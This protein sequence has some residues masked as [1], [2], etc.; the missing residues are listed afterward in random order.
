MSSVPPLLG[1]AQLTALDWGVMLAYFVATTWIGARLAGEQAT[2]RDFF[3][4]GRKLPWPAVAG[5]IV[6]TEISAVTFVS[7][8]FV[9]FRDGGDF[10]Y[11]Q[12]GVIGSLLARLVVGYVLVPAYYRREIFSPYDY[13]GNR[14]GPGVRRVTT[15]LF[16]LGGIL[17]QSARVYLTAIVLEL[18]LAESVYGPLEAATGIS[19]LAWAIGTIG[20]VAIA[21]TLLGG[22]STVIWTDVA[23]FL[24]FLGGAVAAIVVIALRLDGGFAE[25]VDVGRAA[26]KFRFLDAAPDPT[27]T[28]TIWTA[29]IASTWFMTGIFGTDQLMAQRMFCC[30]SE[31][32]ARK[33]I[34]ASWLGNGVTAT[35][36]LVGV[37]LFAFYR[38]YPMEGE[39]AALFAANPERI[40][41]IF[42]L[43][44][45][46]PGLTGLILAGI[47]AAAISSLDSI[48]AALSQTTMS[49]FVLRDG[50]A[51]AATEDDE[52][53]HVRWSRLL[54][55]GWGL[56]LCGAALVAEKVHAFYPSLLDL[57]LA[58]AAYTAGGLLAGF[59]LAFLPLRTDG[60]GFLWS[61][62]LSVLLV[63]ALVWPQT[64]ATWVLAAGAAVAIGTWLVVGRRRVERGFAT[65]TALLV[66]A[67]A[68]LFVVQREASFPTEDGGTARIAFPWCAPAG[69]VYALVLALLLGNRR[70]DPPEST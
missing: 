36:M 23:L 22:I 60:T 19:T 52:R 39:T 2:I 12:L 37:G 48:L 57:A 63:L 13:M 64:W 34:V 26:G 35:V 49:A 43:E 54:V 65:K 3:L 67:L 40:F 11:L 41:P 58:L 27:K 1:A 29:A 59:L 18:L 69:T 4:G 25:I 44:E 45:I 10:T 56:A 47:F 38:A 28:Y 8:P 51:A 17:A 30:R 61:A 62:P 15:A 50:D 32:D 31:R 46:P 21:W 33:A 14:L 42:I 6:A 20:V 24:V 7:V 53:R 68:V 16:S 9:V 55:I 5:S 70:P 66:L